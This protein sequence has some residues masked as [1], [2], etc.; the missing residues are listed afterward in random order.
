MIAEPRGSDIMPAAASSWAKWFKRERAAGRGDVS[1]VQA[2]VIT[3]DGDR[4]SLDLLDD[5]HLQKS[6]ELEL[7]DDDPEK[8]M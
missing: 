8:N 6:S 1:D 4:Q 7:P 5:V 3:A 2:V